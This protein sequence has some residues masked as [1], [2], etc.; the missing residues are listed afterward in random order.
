MGVPTPRLQHKLNVQQSHRSFLFS[1][2]ALKWRN[3][4]SISHELGANESAI[5][6]HCPSHRREPRCYHGHLEIWGQVEVPA[7]L[8]HLCTFNK[9]EPH[10]AVCIGRF[11]A[12]VRFTAFLRVKR[13][14]VKE[15]A[16]IVQPKKNKN[17]KAKMNIV[18]NGV[19]C[20]Y[21]GKIG[22][23]NAECYKRSCDNGKE[24]L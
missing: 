11:A 14:A 8:C 3:N 1:T 13:W 4:A 5:G 20:W 21:C 10:L 17:K 6:L 22:H 19:E 16:I 18:W 15:K 2:D 12:G 7:R 9:G 23:F 24:Y